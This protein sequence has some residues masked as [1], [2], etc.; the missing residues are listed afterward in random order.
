MSPDD[1]RD[2]LLQCAQS[3]V[4]EQGVPACTI[5]AVAQ[6]A[7]VTPQLVHKYFGNRVALLE[8]LYQQEQRAFAQAL[9]AALADANTLEEVVRVFVI[10]NFDQLS[11][12]T[13]IGRLMSTPELAPAVDAYQ[14]SRSRTAGR[15][16]AR[17]LAR[18]YPVLR[19][20]A[21]FVLTLGSAASVAAGDLAARRKRDREADIDATVRFVMAGIRSLASASR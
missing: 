21:E 7:Q 15:L 14:A 18:E 12:A 6:S 16:L 5:D 1:R 9:E 2:H 17:V 10:A 20:S 11:G 19:E 13:A 8:A 3:L 4:E